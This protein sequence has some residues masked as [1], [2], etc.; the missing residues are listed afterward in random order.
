MQVT[1]PSLTN[2]ACCL[3]FIHR[4]LVIRGKCRYICTRFKVIGVTAVTEVTFVARPGTLKT[5][6]RGNETELYP[7]DQVHTPSD[8]VQ[9]CAQGMWVF[10]SLMKT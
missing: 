4:R 9:A 3:Y 6:A 5:A 10:L 2:F 8:C 7:H 1:G